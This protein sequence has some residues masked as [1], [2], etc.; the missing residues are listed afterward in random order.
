MFSGVLGR[1][2]SVAV[3]FTVLFVLVPYLP[4]FWLC[5]AVCGCFTLKTSHINLLC[6]VAKIKGGRQGVAAAL[7]PSVARCLCYHMLPLSTGEG[8]AGSL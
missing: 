5:G 3:L 2:L 1:G 7:H 4:L 8:T 6:E